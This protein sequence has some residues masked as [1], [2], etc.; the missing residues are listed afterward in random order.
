MQKG[1]YKVLFRHDE[2]YEHL[3]IQGKNST[4]DD[5]VEGYPKLSALEVLKALAKN[6]VIDLAVEDINCDEEDERGFVT[7]SST[8]EFTQDSNY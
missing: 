3:V 7:N 8:Q 5:S 2:G 6:G 1:Y 4:L